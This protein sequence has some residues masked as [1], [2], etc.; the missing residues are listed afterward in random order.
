MYLLYHN[1]IVDDKHIINWHNKLMKS[2]RYLESFCYDIKNKT[3][4]LTANE[5][6]VASHKLK[7]RGI[8]EALWNKYNY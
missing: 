6:D 1:N 8:K 5:E 7:V 4:E 2:R 3:T